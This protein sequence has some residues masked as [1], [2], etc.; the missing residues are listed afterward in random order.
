MRVLPDV[1]GIDR[2]FDYLVPEALG[3]QVRV[4]AEVRVPL[5]GRPVGGWVTALD[6]EPP[7]GVTLRP[8]AKVRGAG[9]PVGVVA[10]AGWAAWRWAGARRSLLATASP[11]VAVP[12]LPPRPVR[13]GP[14]AAAVPDALAAEA[15]RT[16]R[17]VLRLPPA[18]DPFPVVAAAAA[19]GDALVVTP[20]TAAARAVAVRL[21]RAG[22]PVALLPRDWATAAAGAVAV[23]A[24][25]AA[26]APVPELS[27]VVVLD[28]HDEALQEERA[29]TWHARDVAAE[30]A[31]RAGVPCVLVSPC[32]SL[33]ALAWGRLVTPSR[34]EERAGWPI[35]EVLDRS[36]DDPVRAGLYPAR[37]VE[38]LRSG[39]RV[40]CVLNRTGRARL[41][42]CSTCRALVRCERCAAAVAQVDDRLRCRRCGEERPLVCTACG[43]GRLKALRLGTARV[44]DELE[45]LA[46]APVVEVTARAGADEVLPDARLIVGTE[47]VLHRVDRA[48]VVVFLDLD[49]E[50]LAPRVRAAEQAL[51]LL[52]RAARLVGGRAGGGRLVLQTRLPRHEVVEAVV[53]ADPGRVA[54]VEAARRAALG[55]PPAT[56]VAL[57]SGPVAAGY[58]EA[59]REG[60]AVEVLGPDEGRYLVR[61]PGH[62]GLCDALAAV[63]RPPGRL[64]VEVDPPRL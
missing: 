26:W 64:R 25:A 63:P 24:R 42:A 12:R 52:A 32:P 38:L 56:A 49:Q 21:R 44:R 20:S 13:A 14:V 2:E 19:G 29:P 45:A 57:V 43:G 54:A 8:V 22:V 17:T 3:D 58:A 59:L 53:H 35:T 31:R 37:T 10:L 61:A 23:G 9:P 39:A 47:A 51:A 60:G 4:G 34:A 41:L 33:E 46:G 36:R 48:D 62:A 30:R 55:L 50:L 15:L 27:A 11:P 5:H 28:E 1:P 18:A 7:A 16:P 6:V 40:V